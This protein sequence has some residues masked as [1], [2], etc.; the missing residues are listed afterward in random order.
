MTFSI[1]LFKFL[2]LS[3]QPLEG[4]GSVWC[5]QLEPGMFSTINSGIDD[6]PKAF[7]VVFGLGELQPNNSVFSL[8]RGLKVS[9]PSLPGSFL[10]FNELQT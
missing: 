10:S 3:L 4:T 5:S 2:L 9:S 6:D 1:G 7:P 8:P